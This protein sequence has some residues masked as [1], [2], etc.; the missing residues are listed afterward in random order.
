MLVAKVIKSLDPPMNCAELV[1]VITLVCGGH[2]YFSMK[3]IL[4]H[5]CNDIKRSEHEIQY[6][7]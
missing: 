6:Y 3:C 1:F 2:K 4:I 7:L 5:I